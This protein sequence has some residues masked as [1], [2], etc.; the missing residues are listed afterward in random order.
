MDLPVT[1][2]DK[3]GE[4]FTVRRWAPADLAALEAMYDAF[5]PKRIAQG[6]PPQDGVARRAWLAAILEQGFHTVVLMDDQLLGHGML[7]PYNG[8]VELANFLHQSIRN[9]GIGTALN[10][11]LV[12]L[13][14][15]AGYDR[16]WLSVEPSNRAAIRSYQ[17]AG[18]QRMPATIWAPEIEMQI[19]LERTS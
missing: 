9:R 13:A 16:L 17:K 10:Q 1:L 14:R 12:D 3:R 19:L 2:L 8:T 5:E 15:E 7:L 6:L 4:P 11:V 18:F